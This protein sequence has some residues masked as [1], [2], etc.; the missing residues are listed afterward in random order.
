MPRILRHSTP[1]SKKYT[2]TTSAVPPFSSSPPP[3]FFPAVLE[4]DDPDCAFALDAGMMVR[5]LQRGCFAHMHLHARADPRDTQGVEAYAGWLSMRVS[6]PT[7]KA[8][9]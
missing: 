7:G 9:V 4:P 6:V 2:I 8:L 5:M 3:I 1:E